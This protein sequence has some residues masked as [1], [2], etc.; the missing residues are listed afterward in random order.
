[1]VFFY[2][3]S[4]STSRKPTKHPPRK[5]RNGRRRCS[6]AVRAT[7]DLTNCSTS[8]AAIDI[9]CCRDLP[10]PPRTITFKP[11]GPSLLF[12]SKGRKKKRSKDLQ[13]Q[14]QTEPVSRR[15]RFKTKNAPTIST[16]TAEEPKRAASRSRPIEQEILMEFDVLLDVKIEER[17]VAR[18]R[19]T[20]QR[21]DVDETDCN[22]PYA[23][24][25]LERHNNKVE[26]YAQ[27]IGS[28]RLQAEADQERQ[29]Q[30]EEEVKDQWDMIVF[31]K[32]AYK[33]L[34]KKKKKSGEQDLPQAQ[35]KNKKGRRKQEEKLD[36]KLDR[37]FQDNQA[38][39]PPRDRP[40]LV[41]WFI[42]SLL[43]WYFWKYRTTF[44]LCLFLWSF[45]SDL[46][47]ECGF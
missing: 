36:E 47:W 45:I 3:L 17:E 24:D 27:Q 26:M 35:K 10:T 7:C 31:K 23:Y 5:T 12:T 32:G 18:P 9:T 29:R 14:F 22:D 4:R 19:S 40:G 6:R 34:P 46:L 25:D 41:S 2:P 44:G 43:F 28:K 38:E 13:N 1:M 33:E 30:I 16:R 37:I 39:T 8:A 21:G 20:R 11:P 42:T 15:T